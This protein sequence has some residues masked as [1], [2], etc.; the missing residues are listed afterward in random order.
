M[1]KRWYDPMISWF[2]KNNKLSWIITILIAILIFYVSSQSFEKGA[3]GPKIPFKAIIYHLSI[4]FIFSFFL[5]ISLSK[6]KYKS[7]VLIAVLLAM[8]YGVFDELHQLFVPNRACDVNDFLTDSIGILSA[9]IIYL[10]WSF[11]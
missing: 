7:F 9:G 6:G 4:F 11:K 5:S 2:E 10:R 3:P 1:Q 8:I